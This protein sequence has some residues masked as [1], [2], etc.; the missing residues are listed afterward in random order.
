MQAAVQN[1]ARKLN[2]LPTSSSL[3]P[4]TS[5]SVGVRHNATLTL[6][7]DHARK[8]NLS[9]QDAKADDQ[10]T[11]ADASLEFESLDALYEAQKGQAAMLRLLASRRAEL[12][13]DAALFQRVADELAPHAS[14][15]EPL[16]RALFGAPRWQPDAE[17]PRCMQCDR[18]FRTLRRRH[19][20]RVCG[21]VV[22]ARCAPVPRDGEPRRCGRCAAREVASPPPGAAAAALPL[23]A[24]MAAGSS[25]AAAPE[26]DA[27]EILLESQ[28]EAALAQLR[29]AS[30]AAAAL[31]GGV[32]VVALRAALPSAASLLYSAADMLQSSAP[33]G[34]L[35]PVAFQALG[36]AFLGALP[37]CTAPFAQLLA[38]AVY[39]YL[40]I[41]W[42][43]AL[44]VLRVLSVHL[45]TRHRSERAVAAAWALC[46]RVNARYCF[47]EARSLGGF[48]VKLAQASSVSSIMP[49]AYASE[50]SKL[51]DA[52]P[53][54]PREAIDA[55]LRTE[56]G[57]DYGD[58]VRLAPGPP[59]G[60][61]TIAQVH[62]AELLLDGHWVD[63]VIKVQHSGVAERLRIDI[64]ASN[65]VAVIFQRLYPH[66]FSDLR[67]IARELASLTMAELDFRLEASSQQMACE[68]FAGSAELAPRVLVPR[69]FPSLVTRRVL[70][71]EY[72]DGMRLDEL[73]ANGADQAKVEQVA[74]TLV[75]AFSATLS[76]PIF[77]VDPHPGNLLVDR[78]T[79][80]LV[81]LDWGQMRRLT[82]TE[83]SAY[84]RVFMAAAMEDPA[85][86]I[87]AC[88][89]LGLGD[90]MPSHTEIAHIPL[91]MLAGL[92]FLLRDS[93]PAERSK[94]D[95]KELE[96]AVGK[97]GAIGT[98]E[99][100]VSGGADSLFKGALLPLSKT[101][102][103]L[104]EVCSRL[105]VALPL[106]QMLT[107]SGYKALLKDGGFDVVP[108]LRGSRFV[109][110]KP[111]AHQQLPSTPPRQSS[112]SRPLTE[113]KLKTPVVGITAKRP[114]PL[115]APSRGATWTPP[116]PLPDS[117]VVERRLA[118]RL[119]AL[120]A[121]GLILGAQLSLVDVYSAAPIADVVVGHTSWLAPHDVT[122][123]TPFPLQ[124]ISRIFLALSV[125]RASDSI[126][127]SAPSL[128][129]TVVGGATVEQILGYTSGHVVHLPRYV[130]SLNDMCDAKAMATAAAADAP[131]LTPGTAQRYLHV[132][133]GYLLDA[134]LRARGSSAALAW[135]SMAE[136]ALGPGG[137]SRLMLSAPTT[138][139][140]EPWKILRAS[141]VED[142]ATIMIEFNRYLDI[143]QASEAPGATEAER[144]NFA[145]YGCLFGK[146]S[147]LEASG[148]R[149][150]GVQ[151]AELHGL[152]AFAT[153]RDTSLALAAAARG[154]IVGRDV[155]ADA[156]RSRR[157]TKQ[158]D[159]APMPRVVSYFEGSEW[160]LGIQLGVAEAAAAGGNKAGG[161]LA[162]RARD[163][164]PRAAIP[165]WGH[166]SS[167]G[168]FALVLAGG[169]VAATLLLN[170]QMSAKASAQVLEELRQIYS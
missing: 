165:S 23:P 108:E 120:H 117:L 86:L 9:V 38:S 56:L 99:Q 13:G 64:I 69:V 121:E 112:R 100:A 33:L 3:Q 46:H 8:Y 50:L 45:G 47:D 125:L 166:V 104:F 71:M 83:R 52:M 66:L 88:H 123:E 70:G 140:A 139:M 62:R 148:I 34:A 122:R 133:F 149:D 78:R 110:T 4:N 73:R 51:Q 143:A 103:L 29:L 57:D 77:N 81:L 136:A 115:S 156:L 127:E 1:L 93:R 128:L 145:S 167:S 16:A 91:T 132:P 6:A 20:C 169:R 130:G 161:P 162:G 15:L 35:P 68:Y 7:I 58:R 44:V 75:D 101:C 146:V 164:R 43:V 32:A 55:L 126:S 157:P 65:L 129:D 85:L 11:Q 19:H 105:D 80:H 116:P 135:A 98:G 27:S 72:I 48:W 24:P 14:E 141:S 158:R 138:R 36:G 26:L 61:A 25:A 142:F 155:L 2:S 147:W 40:R 54:E 109:L 160:G 21:E 18:A 124:E 168:S 106:L 39:R 102:N 134:S 144:A 97:L 53:A 59:I 10:P 111:A 153:A 42:S 163:D 74:R 12:A 17:A 84:T 22:C 119:R 49:A 170:C 63:G 28:I 76:G 96:E 113:S 5:L 37:L 107:L 94:S 79:G 131:T 89:D 82:T 114:P 92:R 159:D 118:A 150:G 67:N 90:E 152:Q 154:E 95:F 41:S 30:R 87:D 137:A 60:S 151:A 31:L